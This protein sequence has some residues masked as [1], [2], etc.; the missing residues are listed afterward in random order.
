MRLPIVFDL[1][2]LPGSMRVAYL[3][4]SVENQKVRMIFNQPNQF[5]KYNS[6]ECHL[7]VPLE[8]HCLTFLLIFHIFSPQ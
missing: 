1:R 5:L 8:P 4:L 3:D 2:F 7:V 6:D